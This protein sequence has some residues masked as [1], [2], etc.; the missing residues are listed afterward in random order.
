M[1]TPDGGELA[2]QMGSRTLRRLFTHVA[3]KV[4]QAQLEGQGN[5]GGFA[6]QVTGYDGKV[7]SGDYNDLRNAMEQIPLGDGDEWISAF[8]RIN[9][10][11][12]M[13][14]LEARKAF[15]DEFDYDLLMRCTE[16]LVEAV[17]A[18]VFFFLK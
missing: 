18:Y 4:V 10:T 7:Q 5:D 8:M 3:I 17:R 2:E 15:L 6:P 1:F 11:V 14:V 16:D 13:R 9:T 12:G